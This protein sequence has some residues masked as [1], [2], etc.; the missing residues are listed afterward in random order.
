[1][2]AKYRVMIRFTLAVL[3]LITL[4]APGP[5]Q[6]EGE[7]IAASKVLVEL[8]ASQNCRACPKA[9]ETLTAVDSARDDVLILT[10]SVDYWDYLGRPD[11]MAMPISA[12]RQG[13]YVD[14]FGLRGPY[15]PQTVY[16]GRKQC[17]GNR[18]RDVER[19]L[20]AVEDDGGHGVVFRQLETGEWRVDAP[21]GLP[22]D[23]HLIDFRAAGD[24]ET[25]M[26]NP[27]TGMTTLAS[28]ATGGTLGGIPACD[29]GCALVVQSPGHGQ[30]LAAL[31][32]Q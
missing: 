9:H 14:T 2:R 6:G 25:D 26:V 24:H 11:P 8:F 13:A 3:A 22:A 10:W 4:A 18:P 29:S 31:R 1:M 17:P 19:R 20:D 30:V 23:V 7:D 12:T 21:I 5:A 32:V 15:T 28:F 27:V 16:N